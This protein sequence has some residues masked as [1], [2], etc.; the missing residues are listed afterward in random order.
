MPASASRRVGRLTCPAMAITGTPASR[1]AAALAAAGIARAYALSDIEP[2]PA[3][4]MA[5]AGP[6]L[7]RLAGQAA[8]DW[9]T[10]AAGLTRRA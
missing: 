10:G 4:C 5:A 7:E 9:L 6:L 1:A 2:D 3:R 8:S